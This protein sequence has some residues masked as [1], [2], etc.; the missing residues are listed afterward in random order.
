M[1]IILFVLRTAFLVLIYVFIFILL[2]HLI[3]DLR[4]TEGLAVHPAAGYNDGGRGNLSEHRKISYGDIAGVLRV[5]FA[6][7]EYEMT[8]AEFELAREIKIGRAPDNE[9]ILPDPFI[10]NNHARLHLRGEQYWLEDLDSKNGT[11]L[12]GILLT[13]PAVL[14]NGDQ[15]NIGSVIFRFVRW[16]YE[17]G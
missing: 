12:N 15:L 13:E 5:E 14:A 11:F 8:G 16:G 17:V 6:P 9:I 7:K 10:S 1:D 3:R 2:I 4:K